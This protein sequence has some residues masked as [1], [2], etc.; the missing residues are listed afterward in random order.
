MDELFLS[1]NINAEEENSFSTLALEIWYMYI[2]VWLLDFVSI[3][4]V[5]ID[6]EKATASRDLK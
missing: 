3:Y 4:V 5:S 1:K 6:Q 2:H